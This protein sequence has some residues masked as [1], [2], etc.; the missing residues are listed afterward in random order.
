MHVVFLW[1][2]HTC[3]RPK[4]LKPCK[5]SPSWQPERQLLLKMLSYGLKWNLS[6]I[7]PCP[8]DQE[9]FQTATK[10]YK[11]S[12]R[13][14]SLPVLALRCEG[15]TSQDTHIQWAAGWEFATVGA[16]PVPYAVQRGVMQ[17]SVYNKE[18]PIHP[19]AHSSRACRLASC[20]STERAMFFQLLGKE[21]EKKRKLAYFFSN[22]QST[23]LTFKCNAQ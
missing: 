11:D 1:G 8:S 13:G 18:V 15:Q 20:V 16:L 3:Q 6:L 22:V 2:L 19:Q 12:C 5:L 21:K 9:L 14:S 23:T 10:I 4:G 17:G 7:L